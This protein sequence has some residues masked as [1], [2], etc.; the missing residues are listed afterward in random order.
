MQTA[1]ANG[2]RPCG[3]RTIKSAS[4][5]CIRSAKPPVQGQQYLDLYVLQ[6]DRARWGQLKDRAEEMIRCIDRSL[7]RLGLDLG[8]LGRPGRKKV[9]GTFSAKHPPGRGRSRCCTGTDT[10][11]LPRRP[12]IVIG[13]QSER[14]PSRRLPSRG[15]SE[16]VA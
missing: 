1:T 16:K 13:S 2:G 7:S 14:Q 15:R 10:F 9:S 3:L 5:I 8:G 4:S 11:F 12:A 6:R